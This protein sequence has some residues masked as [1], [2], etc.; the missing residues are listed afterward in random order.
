MTFYNEMQA[1]AARQLSTKG[2]PL[3]LTRSTAGAYNPATGAA[4]VALTISA[5]IGVGAAFD[6]PA[7]NAPGSDILRGD[8]KILVSATGLSFAPQPGDYLTIGGVQHSV[9]NVKTLAPAGVPVLY[10]VQA[11]RGG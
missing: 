3:M 11:R 2:A 1:M 9:I 7:V 8:K 4:A 5:S 6:F 10:T